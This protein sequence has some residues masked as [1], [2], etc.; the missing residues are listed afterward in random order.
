MPDSRSCSGCSEYTIEEESYK[1]LALVELMSQYI[2]LYYNGAV[3]AMVEA[4]SLHV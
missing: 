2:A 3:C 4:V 1:F